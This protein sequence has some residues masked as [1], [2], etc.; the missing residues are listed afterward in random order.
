MFYKLKFDHLI[1]LQSHAE[2]P[3]LHVHNMQ[4]E[5]SSVNVWEDLREHVAST[6][7][8]C[9]CQGSRL[10]KATAKRC[11]VSTRWSGAE[12]CGKV[13][14]LGLQSG[15]GA[16]GKCS[17]VKEEDITQ[18][19]KSKTDHVSSMAGVKDM[20][21]PRRVH[22]GKHPPQD[23]IIIEDDSDD[24]ENENGYDSAANTEDLSNDSEEDDH[25]LTSENDASST[26]NPISNSCQSTGQRL[27]FNRCRI[28]K[29]TNNWEDK[30]NC[31][32]FGAG[33]FRLF[34]S[35]KSANRQRSSRR[36]PAVHDRVCESLNSD[37]D[38]A[39]CEI[40]MEGS[41]GQIREQWEEAA[42]RKQVSHGMKYKRPLVEEEFSGSGS[43][44][45]P[46]NPSGEFKQEGCNEHLDANFQEHQ[47]DRYS[48]DPP[49][50]VSASGIVY[51]SSQDDVTSHRT[52]KEPETQNPSAETS[53]GASVS[54][55]TNTVEV[56][57]SRDG[58]EWGQNR[59][60]IKMREVHLDPSH[61]KSQQV[62]NKILTSSAAET[63]SEFAVSENSSKWV[64]DREKLKKTAAFRYAE[65]EEWAQ[66]QL[67]LQCQAEEA[68]R[69]RKRIRA[70]ATRKLEM[71]RRQKQRLEEMRET[72]KKDEETMDLKEQLRGQ[73]RA[74]LEQVASKSNDM[75]SL[76]QN[77]GI[78]VEGGAYPLSQQ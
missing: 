12:K 68:R 65:Q 48:I 41:Y 74:Q 5:T 53:N 14:T 3:G 61:P 17:K 29:F 13:K 75:A 1:P 50:L 25:D 51:A 39:N 70:E 9:N 67:E 19:I 64:A 49:D 46:N 11:L 58:H 22:D 54:L 71:E 55:S 76:L 35:I 26:K 52:P 45:Y 20:E 37:S 30:D 2:V 28:P 72:Q 10:L 56:R 34:R 60:G 59:C 32:M 23:I 57:S 4:E 16:P 63:T 33:R 73:V 27:N 31:Q 38:S 8:E 40:I 69:Q 24:E 21:I 42:L 78:P 36:T 15:Q 6:P 43:N 77:L 7:C 44:F 18:N 62:A 66:R 47:F